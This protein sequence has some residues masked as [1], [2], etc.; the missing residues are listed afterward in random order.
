MGPPL[1]TLLLEAISEIFECFCQVVL[2]G[3]S[4]QLGFMMHYLGEVHTESDVCV[5]C[6]TY[7]RKQELH[8]NCVSLVSVD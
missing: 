3:L 1:L 7:L 5:F 6:I 4:E 8:F 2:S